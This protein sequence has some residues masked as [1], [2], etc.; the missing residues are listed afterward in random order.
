M[1]LGRGEALREGASAP[2]ILGRP[3]LFLNNTPS[4]FV[5]Q[6]FYSR[7]DREGMIPDDPLSLLAEPPPSSKSRPK[8]EFFHEIYFKSS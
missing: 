5:G 1:D 4:L 6:L 3:S 8:A 7:G 2:K